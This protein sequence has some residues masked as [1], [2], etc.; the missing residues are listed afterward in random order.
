MTV[1]GFNV[2]SNVN[3]VN[4]IFFIYYE[5]NSILI[6][7]MFW[8]AITQGLKPIIIIILLRIITFLCNNYASEQNVQFLMGCFT[9]MVRLQADM[10]PG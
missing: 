4:Y 9:G 3:T 7:E 5:F 8:I 2:T 6:Q 10:E 1:I